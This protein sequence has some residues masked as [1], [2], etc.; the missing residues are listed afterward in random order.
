MKSEE[1]RPVEGYETY[2]VSNLARVRNA[3]THHIKKQKLNNKGYWFVGLCIT[4]R[5]KK[6][7]MVHRLVAIAFIPNPNNLP[8]VLHRDDN[9][10]NPLPSNLF[11]GTQKDN[12]QDCTRKGRNIGGKV[13][14]ADENR[15]TLYV[16]FSPEGELVCTK[17]FTTLE[18]E[19]G[20]Y[21]C[22]LTNLATGKRPHAAGWRL[23]ACMLE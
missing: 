9:P 12:L 17:N 8:C 11:W 2:E 15:D 1:W 5:K 23:A 18:K 4:G 19:V 22:A 3:K 20:L 7:L 13:R 21:K 10:L 16:F 14:W 6:N